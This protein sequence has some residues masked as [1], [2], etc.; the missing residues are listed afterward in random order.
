MCKMTPALPD[1]ILHLICIQ[2]WHQR[3]F[4]TLFNCALSCKRLAEP[5]VAN[6][7]RCVTYLQR[8]YLYYYLTEYYLLHSYGL[9][10]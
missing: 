3:D 4:N 8:D 6:L 5:A 2:L 9:L 7:Y 10:L 1:D